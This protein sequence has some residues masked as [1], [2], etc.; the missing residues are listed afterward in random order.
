MDLFFRDSFVFDGLGYTLFG[1]KPM[2]AAGYCK[3]TRKCWDIDDF[4][5]ST[6]YSFCAENLRRRRGWEILQR[7][8]DLFPVKDYGIVQCKN[9]ADDDFT[10]VLFINKKAVLATVEKHLVDFKQ[11][12][13]EEITPE[14]LLSRILKSDDVFGDVLKNH[15]GL[16]GILLGYG[17]HNAWLF[18]RRE[19]I[20]PVVLKHRFS[21]KKPRV[22]IY[23]NEIDDLNQR[24]Q[25]FDDR[26]ILDFNP[27]LLSLPCF[28][29]D[30]DS[31]ET[32]QL[33]INYERQYRE[34][35]R[36]YRKGDFLQ[37]TLEQMTSRSAITRPNNG[38]TRPPTEL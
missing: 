22:Q 33:K 24:L 35:I 11:V 26:G 36:R 21:L 38:K 37:I 20:D 13:G 32:K 4:L 14:I 6:F 5:D 12:L 1:D 23:Q 19:E 2:T 27:L 29:A 31:E 10:T 25:G 15:Q 9:F 30:P 7:H 34:I 17:R 8:R 16:I 18:Q 3:S 28:A